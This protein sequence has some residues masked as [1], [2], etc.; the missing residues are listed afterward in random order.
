L[1]RK[2]R[3]VLRGWSRNTTPASRRAIGL[4]ALAM[5]VAI[6]FVLATDRQDGAVVGS[7][8]VMSGDT[9]RI[10]GETYRL[11][12]IAAPPL[13]YFCR[14][15]DLVIR[16]GEKARE[17]MRNLIDGKAVRCVR[18]AEGQDGG[19]P[20]RCFRDGRDLAASVVLAGYALSLEEYG[21]EQIE[22]RAEKRGL[23]GMEFDEDDLRIAAR[24]DRQ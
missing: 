21:N 23:W 12:G 15:G 6:V 10:A 2:R 18:L 8:R 4:V 20:A 7:A 14:D 9:L 3:R 11:S 17:T 16:C 1:R 22:A 13:D 5:M 24:R 19:I